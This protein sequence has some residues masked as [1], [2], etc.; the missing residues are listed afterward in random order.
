MIPERVIRS[1]EQG[2]KVAF[3]ER[4]P[5]VSRTVSLDLL[6]SIDNRVDNGKALDEV[7]DRADAQRGAS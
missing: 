4:R 1:R 7:V 3:D 2:T 5:A 6:N